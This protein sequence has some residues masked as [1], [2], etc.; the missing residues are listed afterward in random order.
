MAE[1]SPTPDTIHPDALFEVTPD[2]PRRRLSARGRA[3]RARAMPLSDF[4][5]SKQRE[6]ADAVAQPKPPPQWLNFGLC[7]MQSRAWYEWHW[8]RG[9]DPEAKRVSLPPAIRLAVIERDGMTCR[10]CG[11]PVDDVADIR[12]DHIKPVAHGGSDHLSNLQVAHSWCNMSKG[13]RL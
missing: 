7:Q 11:D 4:P 13:A 3:R 6:I 10:L 2:I 9:I 1:D 12:I 8:Q 5:E